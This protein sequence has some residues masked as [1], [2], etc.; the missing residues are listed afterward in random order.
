MGKINAPKRLAPPPGTVPPPPMA[1]F[2]PPANGF[3]ALGKYMSINTRLPKAAFDKKLTGSVI[4]SFT[5]GSDHKISNVAFIKGIGSGCDEEV[6]RALKSFD[7]TIDAKPGTYKMA[8][9]FTGHGLA[10]PKPASETLHNDP[11]FAGEV[12]VEYFPI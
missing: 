11:S 10:A 2:M 3:S 5:V 1:P 7:G 9:T 4:E 12:V 6:T 8:I